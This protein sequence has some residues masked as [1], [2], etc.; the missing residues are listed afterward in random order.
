MANE[1]DAL[2][3]ERLLAQVEWVR[4]LAGALVGRGDADEV[5]Q[6]AYLQ[7]LS[8]P[9]RAVGNLRGWLT[10]VVRNAAHYRARVDERRATHERRAPVPAPAADPAESVARAE[11][12]RRV[13]DAVLALDEPYRGTLLMRFFDDLSAEAIAAARGLPVETVRTRVK[14]GLALLRARLRD[15]DMKG[16]AALACSGAAA[17]EVVKMSLAIK[18]TTAA[19]VV[20]AAGWTAWIAT[21][22][23]NAPSQVALHEE[24]PVAAESAPPIAEPDAARAPEVPPAAAAVAPDQAAAPAELTKPGTIHGVV[25]DRS[26]RPVADASIFRTRSSA[27]MPVVPD[28]LAW[29]VGPP[30]VAPPVG[31]PP[32]FR[33][34]REW[35]LSAHTDAEGRFEIGGLSRFSDWFVGAYVPERGASVS[36]QVT[37]GDAAAELTLTLVPAVHLHGTVRD[38]KGALLGGVTVAVRSESRPQMVES[39][40]AGPELGTWDAGW[41]HGTTFTLLPRAPGFPPDAAGTVKLEPTSPDGAVDLVLHRTAQQVEVRGPIVDEAGHA[42]DLSA[43][44]GELRA[45]AGATGASERSLVTVAY[46]ERIWKAPTLYDLAEYANFVRPVV[47]ARRMTGSYR[48]TVAAAGDTYSIWLPDSFHGDLTLVV[49]GIFAAVA[50][51]DD[52]A[53]G[54]PLVFKLRSLAPPPV[55]ATLVVAAVDAQ[56]GTPVALS[57]A[58]VELVRAATDTVEYAPAMARCVVTPAGACEFGGALGRLFVRVRHPGF[59]PASAEVELREAGERREVT[60]RLGRPT[61]GVRGRA[62]LPDGKPDPEA[63]VHL[64]RKTVGGWIDETPLPVQ[65]N[66]AGTF[67]IDRIAAADYVVVVKFNTLAAPGVAR[68]RAAD[69]P[70]YVELRAVPASEVAVSLTSDPPIGQVDTMYRIVDADGIPVVNMFSPFRHYVVAE[71]PQA[72]ACLAPG[73]YR[74]FVWCVGYREATTELTVPL[75]GPLELQLER[76]H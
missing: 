75:A 57:E 70:P 4:R 24:R 53:S 51:I 45:A 56:S 28:E 30:T 37:L 17:V 55:D 12:H 46:H 44:L 3:P 34:P 14:R 76:A 22:D 25:K 58:D 41:W 9:P 27:Y 36:S 43:R 18:W 72:S 29:S 32:N 49:D 26:G 7:A 65:A 63:T 54:P 50:R 62:L 47:G 64:F 10:T 40:A 74:L 73:R 31:A 21:G 69:S 61:A 59:A 33:S 48:G 35:T 42:F 66:A 5:A 16:V 11:L 23:G 1:A 60:L 6:Q 39:A 2:S 8:A 52:A 19:A 20:V 38:E 13:V 71:K 67:E 68:V 15:D